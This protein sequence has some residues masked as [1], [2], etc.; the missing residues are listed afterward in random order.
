MIQNNFVWC[1]CA[2]RSNDRNILS[3]LYQEKKIKT[4]IPK[5]ILRELS[6]VWTKEIPFMFDDKIYIQN[7]VVAMYSPIGSLLAKILWRHYKKTSYQRV[8]GRDVL[9]THTLMLISKKF[10]F[11]FTKLNSY[12]P[13]IKFT[14]SNNSCR[15]NRNMCS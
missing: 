12:Q 13:N 11:I 2:A 8:I 6:Y 10:D 14:C 4:S 15:S 5:K 7:M 9:M 3:K 1:Q